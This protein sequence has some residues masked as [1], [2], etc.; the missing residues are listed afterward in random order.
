MQTVLVADNVSKCFRIHKNLP[1]TLR[2]AIIQ[3][4][5][6]R[7]EPIRDLWALRDISFSVKQGTVLGLIGHNGAGKS[8]LLRLLCG[9]GKPTQ[10][11]FYRQGNIG[12]LLELGSGF[13]PDMTGRENLMT[14]GILCG[15]TK[16]QVKAVGDDIIHFAELEEFIDQPVRT[17][18]SGM[19]LRLAF[20]TAIHFDPDYLIIDEV[21]AVGDSRFQQKCLD[22]L[23][24]FRAA[25]KSLIIASHD[26]EQVRGLCNEVIVLEEGRVVMQ[27]EPESAIS[28]YHDLMRQRSDRRAR[29]LYDNEL[30]NLNVSKG[31]RLGTQEASFTNVYIYN[32]QN[33]ITDTVFSGDSITVELEYSVAK[34]IPD[35]SLILGIYTET[36]TKCFETTVPSIVSAFGKFDTKGILRCSLPVLPLLPGH[37]YLNAGI[38]PA[39]WSFVYDYHWQ[40]YTLHILNKT[41]LDKNISGIVSIEPVWAESPPVKLE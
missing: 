39:D 15:L 29:Q 13:H 7:H 14:G 11:H 36:N 24:A 22:R 37:Y 6:G 40:M 10:G 18:S 23:K 20:S 16:R 9:L 19:Y 17:Y 41:D 31:T 8:T 21:L 34:Q 4:L 1:R 26:L 28:C 38:Y 30:P 35:M 5:N 27:G 25:G 32:A 3:R 2:D 12:S 33:K